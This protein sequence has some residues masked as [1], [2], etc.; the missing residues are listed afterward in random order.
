MSHPS[1]VIQNVG[2]FIKR[3]TLYVQCIISCCHISQFY[4]VGIDQW[5]TKLTS[6]CENEVMTSE[7]IFT[8]MTYKGNGKDKGGLALTT[9]QLNQKWTS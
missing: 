8:T 3:A 1:H 9:L 5:E 6:S 7:Y 2:Q 4:V